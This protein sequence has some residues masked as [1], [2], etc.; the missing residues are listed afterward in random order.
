[1]GKGYLVVV[2]HGSEKGVK[3]SRVPMNHSYREVR[4][5]RKWQIRGAKRSQEFCI[6]RML[7]IEWTLVL[8]EV[9]IFGRI[10]DAK[11]ARGF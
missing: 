6:G 5:F 9:V 2:A 4:L 10:R 3:N 11:N 8:R 1:M 7:G